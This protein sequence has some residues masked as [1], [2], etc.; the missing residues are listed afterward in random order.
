MGLNLYSRIWEYASIGEMIAIIRATTV[1]MIVGILVIY[2][3]GLHSLPK[4]IYI[5]AWIMMNVLI[6]SSRISLRLFKDR[7]L[8]QIR[9][10]ARPTLIVGA[11]DAGAILAREIQS[12]TK[13][14]MKVV[15]FVDDDGAKRRRF[16][17]GVPVLGDRNRIHFLVRSLS[18][19]K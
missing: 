15:G 5:G 16:L 10:Q 1:S 13:L 17:Y 11:G 8:I 18:L 7:R 9:T 12:N 3:F 2:I 19:K 6:G 14:N 4:S